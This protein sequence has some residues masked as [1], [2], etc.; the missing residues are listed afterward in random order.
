MAD[1]RE[2]A[3]RSEKVRNLIGEVPSRVLR[4]GMGVLVGVIALLLLL[5]YWIPYPQRAKVEVEIVKIEGL[6]LAKGVVKVQDSRRFRVGQRATLLL[7]GIDKNNQLEGRI[8][9]I[10]ES[11]GEATLFIEPLNGGENSFLSKLPTG[12]AT[13]YLSDTPLLKRVLQKGVT[14][15]K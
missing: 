6:Y 9:A 2:I 4:M 10:T 13:L 3:L 14:S 11:K 12:E 7:F 8:D 15:K 1:N 5:M